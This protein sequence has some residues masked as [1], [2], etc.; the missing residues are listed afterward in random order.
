MSGGDRSEDGTRSALQDSSRHMTRV[1]S[2]SIGG[3][4]PAIGWKS[5]CALATAVIG[6]HGPVR[7]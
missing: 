6:C 4:P 2:W 3:G 1:R 7:R 5:L